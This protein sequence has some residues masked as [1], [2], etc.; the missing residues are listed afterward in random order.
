MHQEGGEYNMI[1]LGILF[2]SQGQN[3]YHVLKVVLSFL[4]KLTLQAHNSTW[5]GKTSK[6]VQV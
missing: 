2:Q 3:S 4:M 6:Y 1:S 5:R